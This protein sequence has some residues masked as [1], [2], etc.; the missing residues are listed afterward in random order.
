MIS[1]RLYKP[2]ETVQIIQGNESF[3]GRISGIT[4]AGTVLIETNN[5][6]EV[7][8]G[9]ITSRKDTIRRDQILSSPVF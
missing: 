2:E 1:Q 9:E 6:I 4:E 5:G 7:I 8:S 3:E